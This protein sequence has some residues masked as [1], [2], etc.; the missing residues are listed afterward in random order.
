M[1]VLHLGRMTLDNRL[2]ETDCDTDVKHPQIK[3]L[4]IEVRYHMTEYCMLIG[5]MFH[6]R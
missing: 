3:P 6:Y 5:C 1:L 2:P 4:T